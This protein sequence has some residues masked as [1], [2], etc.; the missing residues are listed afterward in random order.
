MAKATSYRDLI[1]TGDIKKTNTYRAKLTSVHVEPGFNLRGE[2]AT[3]YADIKDPV[4]REEIDAMVDFLMDGGKFPPLEI[5]I[6]P[7]GGVWLVD[8]H[9]RRITYNRAVEL[10]APLADED[11]EVY[12]D[13]RAFEGNDSERVARIMTS[14]EGRKLTPLE[15]ANGYK[16]LAA[17]NW[18]AERIAK[19]VGKTRPHVEGLLILANANTDVHMLVASGK[20]SAA[21]AVDAVRK[22]NEKAGAFL[23][24]QF[25]KA[26]AAGGKKVTAGTLKPKALPRAVVDDLYKTSRDFRSKLT[27]DAARLVAEFEAGNITEGKVEVDVEALFHL[28]A[29]LVDAEKAEAEQEAKARAK[30]DKAAQQEIDTE[31]GADSE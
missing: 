24:G 7:E 9:R 25:E 26:K 30:A 3:T 14:A 13:V 6:R 12:V 16:R 4:F 23:A 11:G 22:H 17:F 28:V 21:I 29:S 19:K 2:T 18:D 10:G 1:G 31:D 5:R 27:P 8:G 20:V 15:T